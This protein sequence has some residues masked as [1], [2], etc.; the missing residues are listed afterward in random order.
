MT[1]DAGLVQLRD[2]AVRHAPAP[3][4]LDTVIEDAGRQR[5]AA[6]YL[7]T[8]LIAGVLGD[9]GAAPA[10]WP[11]QYTEPTER[12]GLTRFAPRTVRGL[13]AQLTPAEQ[14]TL[15]SPDRKLKY[16]QL[17]TGFINQGAFGP[18][19]G[20]ADRVRLAEPGDSP[21]PDLELLVGGKVLGRCKSEDHWE[22][23]AQHLAGLTEHGDPQAGPA[24]EPARTGKFARQLKETGISHAVSVTTTLAVSVHPIG[25]AAGL[26]TRLIRSRILADREHADALH[27]LGQ[28]LR[29]LRDQAD[30]ELLAS[31]RRR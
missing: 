21:G 16:A 30:G 14:A 22:L 4:G 23:V 20:N 27:R 1:A 29:S 10:Q 3:P 19:C 31:Q 5:L 25:A 13:D 18:L 7:Y 28:V 9:Q 12:L 24:S 11:H 2:D 6:Y 26:G 8:A 17:L 15:R